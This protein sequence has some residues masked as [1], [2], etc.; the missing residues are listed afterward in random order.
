[1]LNRRFLRIKVYQALYGFWQADGAS[2]ARNEKELFNG[3]DRTYD[4]FLSLLLVFG[5]LRHV[6]ELRMTE[7]QKK[8]L[9]TKDDLK[10]DRRFVD[11]RLVK[12]FSDSNVLRL[13]AEKRRIS[14]VGNHELF[15]R[16]WREIKASSE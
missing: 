11:D 15:T 16:M 13:E 1:M 7:Q 14:W 8:H 5:E 2:A 10:P 6:A 3:I 4:L 12:L 9:P